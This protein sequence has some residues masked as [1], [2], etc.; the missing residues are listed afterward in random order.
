MG[1]HLIYSKTDPSYLQ[2]GPHLIYK[3]ARP[4][5]HPIYT[6]FHGEDQP[7]P[8]LFIGRF[9]VQHDALAYTNNRPFLRRSV[10]VDA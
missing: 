2:K 1:P 3:T 6:G 5:T 7:G 4:G 9:C 8:I 10:V